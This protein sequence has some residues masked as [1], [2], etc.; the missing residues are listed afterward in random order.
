MTAAIFAFLF[1]RYP[2]GRVLD[3]LAGAHWGL[4]LLLMIPYGGFYTND[5][6]DYDKFVA[7]E[8]GERS[9]RRHRV[10]WGWCVVALLLAALLLYAVLR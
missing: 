5:S 4:F 10:P 8:L 3:T 6:F 2:V 9:T 1:G 7:E